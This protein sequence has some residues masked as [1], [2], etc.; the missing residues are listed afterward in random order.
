[1]RKT[2][3]TRSQSRVRSSDRKSTRLNSSH[4]QISYALL[5]LKK[6]KPTHR[7]PEA[8]PVVASRQIASPCAA[9]TWVVHVRP[10]HG[11]PLSPPSVASARPAR[12]GA[13]RLAH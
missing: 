6:K 3:S 9:M 11:L 4:S 1:M 5:C 2:T 13:S 7:H 12:D 10:P 8:Q